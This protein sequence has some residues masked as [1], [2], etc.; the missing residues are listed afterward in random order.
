MASAGSERFTTEAS[1]L[2]EACSCMCS[3]M[4][5]TEN[6]ENSYN[7]VQHTGGHQWTLTFSEDKTSC[8]GYMSGLVG[9]VSLLFGTKQRCVYG[10]D[11][12]CRSDMQSLQRCGEMRLKS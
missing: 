1:K 4:K 11:M 7:E 8:T 10:T 3:C 6:S 12:Y 5:Y 2:G 9:N